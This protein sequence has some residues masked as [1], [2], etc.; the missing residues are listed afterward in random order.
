MLLT[1]RYGTLN[2]LITGHFI[3]WQLICLLLIYMTKPWNMN[4]NV[5]VQPP[6]DCKTAS[7]YN[8]ILSVNLCKYSV[9]FMQGSLGDVENLELHPRLLTYPLGPGKH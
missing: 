1:H 7:S 9:E 5:N 2:I 3:L 4:I 8:A 6:V